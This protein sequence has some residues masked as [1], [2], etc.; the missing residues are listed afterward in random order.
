MICRLLARVYMQLAVYCMRPATILS[1]AAGV[2]VAAESLPCGS[3][4]VV[5]AL[6][7]RKLLQ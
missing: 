4:W 1:S 2:F 5:S 6:D 3:V 7:Q